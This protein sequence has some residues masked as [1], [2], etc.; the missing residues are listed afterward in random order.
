MQNACA[1]G[2][3]VQR[4][5]PML[6]SNNRLPVGVGWLSAYEGDAVA[7]TESVTPLIRSR[8]FGVT[9]CGRCRMPAIQ[10]MPPPANSSRGFPPAQ[11]NGGIAYTP[12]GVQRRGTDI[13]ADFGSTASSGA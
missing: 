9:C 7:D 3:P 1:P 13:T 5:Q 6:R 2:F 11:G 8:V 4:Q 10:F 12:I